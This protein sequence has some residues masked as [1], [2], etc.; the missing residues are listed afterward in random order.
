[1]K[2]LFY[3]IGIGFV[4]YEIMWI[5][6][7]KSQVEKS[8]KFWKETKLNKGKKWDEMTEDYKGLLFSK[9]VPNIILTFWM[10]CGL[11]TFN[12]LPFLL[13]LVWSFV[14]ITPISNLFRYSIAYTVLHWFN[15]LV[16]FAFGVFVI[17]NSY[18]LK[19]DVYEYFLVWVNS[20]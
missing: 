6:N 14:I 7:P 17:I 10:V 11:L 8:K 15:S 18:H 1:M 19:I 2:H 20:L 3:L 4:I 12:W 5:L 13:K 16:G 9:G